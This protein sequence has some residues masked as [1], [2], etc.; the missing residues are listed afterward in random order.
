[1]DAAWQ[2]PGSTS[3]A[4]GEVPALTLALVGVTVLA[5]AIASALAFRR[6]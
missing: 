4:G 6:R 3:T 5:V 2:A 1:V